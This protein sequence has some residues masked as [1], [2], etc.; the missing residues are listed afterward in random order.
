MIF[1]I[2]NES[3]TTLNKRIFS[4][5]NH[6]SRNAN[7]I[8]ILIFKLLHFNIDPFSCDKFKLFINFYFFNAIRSFSH[9]RTFIFNAK[10]YLIL[11]NINFSVGVI[12]SLRILLNIH[13]KY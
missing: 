4:F 3:I 2:N 9:Y 6:Q 5:F 10:D 7:F 1:K 12:E 8:K 13:T 11:L